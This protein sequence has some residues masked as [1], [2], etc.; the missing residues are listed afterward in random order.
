MES[1]LQ[2][3]RSIHLDSISAVTHMQ[4][5]NKLA[6]SYYYN[7]HYKDFIAAAQELEALRGAGCLEGD[8]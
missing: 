4:I 6:K 3:I 7:R 5:A 8:S 1:I 2:K